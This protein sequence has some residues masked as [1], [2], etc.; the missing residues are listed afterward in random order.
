MKTAAFAAAV[1]LPAPFTLERRDPGPH[2]VAIGLLHGGIGH[3][4]I[5]GGPPGEN[6]ARMRNSSR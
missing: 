1:S 6:A 4:D 3:S 5:L 2:D